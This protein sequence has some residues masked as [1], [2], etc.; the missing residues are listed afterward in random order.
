MPVGCSPRQSLWQHRRQAFGGNRNQQGDYD[1]NVNVCMY[2]CM[3]PGDYRKQY[4]GVEEAW[5]R[6]DLRAGHRPVPECH[7]QPEHGKTRLQAG[8]PHGVFPLF[9]NHTKQVVY[10]ILEQ[11]CYDIDPDLPWSHRKRLAKA[12][13]LPDEI[14][15]RLAF[16]VHMLSLNLAPAWYH[17]RV[18]WADI[19]NSVLPTTVRKANMQALAHKGGSGWFSE[20][21]PFFPIDGSRPR[22]PALAHSCS[23]LGAQNESYNR[24][25]QK[26]D[27]ALA[28]SECVRVFWMP[29]L[30]QGILH[31]RRSRQNLMSILAQG[32]LHLEMLGSGFPGDHVTGMATF[33]QKLRAAVNLRFHKKQPSTVFVD[34]GGLMYR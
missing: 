22:T 7:P 1:C 6:A 12:A 3:Q 13:L 24:R 17:R 27:L 16:G 9:H 4:D 33:V 18:V 5:R 26:R 2:A 25:G 20:G 32:K 19:C 31:L 14:E 10:D 23:Y 15:K 11:R 21:A 34:R 8:A 30:A 29:I 28:G